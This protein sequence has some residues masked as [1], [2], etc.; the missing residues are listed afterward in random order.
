MA[1]VESLT[2]VEVINV[3]RDQLKGRWEELKGRLRRSHGAATGDT[4]RE[5]K[6]AVEE[7]VGKA[8]SAAG[9]F[10]EDVRREREKEERKPPV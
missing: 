6:G 1:N 2:Q 7:G 4:G 5:V 9:D 8:R 10:A 3:N